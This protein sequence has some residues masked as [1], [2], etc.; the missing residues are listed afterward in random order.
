MELVAH[1][2]GNEA[3]RAVEGAAIADL[4]EIDIH[5]WRGRL[6]VR[7]AKRLWLLQRMW[8]RWHLLERDT[9]VPSLEEILAVLPQSTPL[10]LDLKGWRPKMVSMVQSIV[11]EERPI[12]VSARSWWLLKRVK[13]HDGVRILRSVGA[14][15][16]LWLVLRLRRPARASGVVIDQRLLQP[17]IALRL[18]KRSPMIFSWNVDSEVR[19]VELVDMG[20]TGLI[21]DDPDLIRLLH[22]R[23]R[24]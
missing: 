14:N 12:V 10:L 19:A 17:E 8:E 2:F 5:L 13:D 6:E 4:I 21:I 24:R 11:G 20:V 22:S 15:W 3:R 9:P 1:R 18:L 7:H 16:Q 23:P